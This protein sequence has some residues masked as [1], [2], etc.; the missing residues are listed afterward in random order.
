MSCAFTH[1]SAFQKSLKITVILPM[2]FTHFR[3]SNPKD[4]K[5]ETSLLWFEEMPPSWT[6]QMTL[7]GFQGAG[8]IL[9][10]LWLS[11][12]RGRVDCFNS[13]WDYHSAYTLILEKFGF[14]LTWSLLKCIWGI[15]IPPKTPEENCTFPDS[16]TKLMA[17][18]I[19]AFI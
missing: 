9:S 3:A 15:W 6:C 18:G 10:S 19:S 11:V 8:T 5:I 1:S 17:L 7:E 4:P 13:T 14:V 2:R 16:Q 12:P